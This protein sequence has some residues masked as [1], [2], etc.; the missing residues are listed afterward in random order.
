MK[1]IDL[2]NKRFGKLIVINEIPE[3]KGGQIYWHCKC[4]C[5]KE[6][7]IRGADLKNGKTQSCGCLQKERTS[8]TLSSNLLNKQFNR[9][10]VIEKTN[11][12]RFGQI[13]W[14]CKCICGKE[15][16]TIS[17]YLIS[18]DTQS[19]GCLQ[20]E[21]ASEA[22]KK[23]LLGQRFGKLVVIE[24]T[25]QRKEKNIIWKCE[26]DC[27]NISYVRGHNLLSG[28]TTSCGCIKS[29]GEEKIIKIL[30]EN[31]ID[32]IT[33]KTFDSCRFNETNSLAKFDFYLPNYNILIEYDGEQHFHSKQ[34][35]WDTEENYK[36]TK[37]RDNY[38]NEWCKE[39]NIP[40]I[41]IPYMHLKDLCLEDLLINSKFFI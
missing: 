16:K 36:A 4:D 6:K 18:G 5:G 30:K 23:N 28:D 7:D 34:I 1:K 38:K 37:I 22:S 2:T 14:L 31:N 12:R 35:G 26:C 11:E 13:V 24:E 27:G 17:N 40:L 32:F 21:R 9:L 3:R 8:E 20:K 29:K 25:L 41:R 15:I 10:T 33:Q 19:C 39:N